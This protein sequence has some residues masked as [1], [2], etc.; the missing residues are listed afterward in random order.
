L[1]K[2]VKPGHLAEYKAGAREDVVR[3]PAPHKA[4]SSLSLDIPK[5]LK[6]VKPVPRLEGDLLALRSLLG[7]ENPT[8]MLLQASRVYAIL[9][10]F[11]DTSGSFLGS[12][13][14]GDNSIRYQIGT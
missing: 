5:P 2:A 7:R 6:I 1:H 12:T 14:L 11:A 4:W 9:Y 3:E 10:G 8:Q 13:V